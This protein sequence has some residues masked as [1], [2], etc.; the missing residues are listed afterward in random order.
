MHRQRID[1]VDVARAYALAL[2]TFGHAM[3]EF[4]LWDELSDGTVE[5]ARLLTRTGTPL[6]ILMFGMMIEL[7]HV[8]RAER[9]G[10]DALRPRLRRRALECWAGY[11]LVSVVAL[12]PDRVDLLDV[13]KSTV[14]LAGAG[15]GTIL[16]VYALALAATPALLRVRLRFGAGAAPGLLALLWAVDACV[17]ARFDGR[18]AGALAYPFDFVVGAGRHI[19]GPS[20]FHSFTFVLAG[21]ILAGGLRTWQERGVHDFRRRVGVV[22]AVAGVVVVTLV[23]RDG[24]DAVLDGFRLY[25]GYR[26][27]NAIGYFAIGIIGAALTLLALALTVPRR[28]LPR[29][30]DIPLQLGRSSLLAFTLGSAGLTVLDLDQRRAIGDHGIIAAIGAVVAVMAVVNWRRVVPRRRSDRPT[31][32]PVDQ[33]TSTALPTSRWSSRSLKASATRSN[34]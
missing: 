32:A 27:D 23:W 3:G 17:L 12:V 30:T 21:M 20:L 10:V 2:V 22:T 18:D 28:D 11:L 29:W 31:S 34:A 4:G 8:R 24:I 5:V 26:R 33:G 9:D 19:R 25:R 16:A 6:F 13:A 1:F 15:Y 14:L 7:V